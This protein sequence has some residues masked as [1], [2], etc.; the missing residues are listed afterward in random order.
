MRPGASA[1]LKRI[2]LAQSGAVSERQAK[3]AAS[4]ADQ[5]AAAVLAAQRRVDAAQGAL[6][7]AKANLT[8][9]DIREAETATVRRQ[10]A[11]QEAEVSSAIAQTARTP[12]QRTMLHHIADTWQRLAS[13]ADDEGDPDRPL[14]AAPTTLM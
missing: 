14:N 6:T 7:T 1:R 5:Q 12:A 13:D 3:V 2:K 4:T 8:N 10:V 9:P 11:Q